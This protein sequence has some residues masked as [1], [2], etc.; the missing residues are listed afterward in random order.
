MNGQPP[1]MQPP[2]TGRFLAEAAD[3]GGEASLGRRMRSVCAA[4]RQIFGMPDYDRYLTHAAVTHPGEPVL[5]RRD[6]CAQAIER[7]YGRNAGRCC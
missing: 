7:R 3:G 4:C 6:Y 2:R 5:S 1:A